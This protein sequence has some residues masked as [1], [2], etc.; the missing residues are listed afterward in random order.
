[1][2]DVSRI[3]VAKIDSI[4]QDASRLR[5]VKALGEL[6]EG[7]LSRARRSD[8]REPLARLYREAKI[9]ERRRFAPSR[10]MEGDRFERELA[11]RRLGKL[12]RIRGRLDVGLGIQK[13]TQPFGRA[14]RAQQ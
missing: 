2:A 12:N 14:G 9:V 5:I 4:E 7:G 8:H 1:L 10:I 3:G 11:A 13:L 6:E